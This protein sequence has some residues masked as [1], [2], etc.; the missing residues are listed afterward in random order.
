MPFGIS[1]D[2]SF[3]NTFLSL[4]SDQQ[5]NALFAIVGWAILI[6]VFFYMGAELWVKYREA[7]Y[8]KKWKWVLLAVDVPADEIQSPKAVEQIFAQLSGANVN[9]NFGEKY[10][11]GMKQKWFSL[12]IISIE[13]YI[14][15]LIYTESQ[16]RD[17][18]EA[19]IY[20]QYP[21]TEITEVEDYVS[22]IPDKFP[23]DI[24]DVHVVEYGLANSDPFP[25]RTY[26]EF[27]HSVT[28]DFTFNDPMAAILENFTRIGAGEN[29][30]FQIIILPTSD[31]WKKEGIKIVKDIVAQKKPAAKTSVF[32]FLGSIPLAIFSEFWNHVTMS[33]PEDAAKDK[34]KEVAPGKVSEL[35]PGVK[36]TVASIESKISKVGFRAKIRA[37]YG[38]RKE[39]FNP[40]KCIQG[41]TGSL[42]QFNFAGRNAIIP[43]MTTLIHY[44]FKNYRT[45][46]RKRRFV[47]AYKKR[48]IKVGRKPFILNVEELATLWH[49]PL[50]LVKTPLLQKTAAK[51]AEPPINLPTETFESPL[52]KVG[53]ARAAPAEEP[54]NEEIP[55]EPLMYG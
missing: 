29:L 2:L 14:Q 27:E 37:V 42:N 47:S 50:P 38:A 26:S 41:L 4:P 40:S 23:N 5:S 21:R 46:E 18:V 16:F 52:R 24:D 31:D 9:A 53:E 49:F 13:G 8:A 25:I 43:K 12:E 48:K 30:W 55:P 32:S 17:L 6:L 1:I 22:N 3:W 51:R 28:M 44:A 36:D 35:T 34:K 20:A 7:L 10:W 54:K 39:V 19:T 11:K 15:F 33:F 45:K